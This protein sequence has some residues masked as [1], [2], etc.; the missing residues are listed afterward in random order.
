M[1]KICQKLTR[2]AY[3]KKP[4]FAGANFSIP[5]PQ[6]IAVIIIII[7]IITITKTPVRHTVSAK[8]AS[9]KIELSLDMTSYYAT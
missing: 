9:I 6:I 2:G 5:L 1:A 8:M 3:L 4:D 7:I